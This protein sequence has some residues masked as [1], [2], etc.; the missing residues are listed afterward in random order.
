LKLPATSC[1]ESPI[2]KENIIL[3][4]LANPAASSGECARC[5]IHVD[6]FQSMVTNIRGFRI[7]KVI[8]LQVEKI[9]K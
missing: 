4:S 9:N 1:G 8:Y 3:Y 6:I 7:F 2:V 5:S